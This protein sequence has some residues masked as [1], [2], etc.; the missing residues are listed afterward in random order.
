MRQLRSACLFCKQPR[1]PGRS[2]R[3]P[4]WQRPLVTDD[5][6]WRDWLHEQN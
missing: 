6:L 5:P 3:I 4:D 2:G 1:Q